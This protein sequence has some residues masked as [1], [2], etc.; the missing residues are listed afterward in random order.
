MKELYKLLD[1]LSKETDLQKRNELR[2]KIDCL[3]KQSNNEKLTNDKQK[4]YKQFHV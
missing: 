3:T 2:F 1:D 4:I